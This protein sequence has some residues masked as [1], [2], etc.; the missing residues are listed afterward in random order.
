MCIP[1]CTRLN[2]GKLTNKTY[3]LNNEVCETLKEY[4]VLLDIIDYEYIEN[5]KN[6]SELPYLNEYFVVSKKIKIQ[7]T[8]NELHKQHMV[9]GRSKT[10]KL[11]ILLNEGSYFL[12]IN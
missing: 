8:F 2:P 6:T 11:D 1:I 5:I 7:I 3:K 9:Y 4:L 12:K 10:S